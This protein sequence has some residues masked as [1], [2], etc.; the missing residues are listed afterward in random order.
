MSS[1]YLGN[2]QPV[3]GTRDPAHTTELAT[4][5]PIA[6]AKAI[7]NGESWPLDMLPEKLPRVSCRVGP[8]RGGNV[9]EGEEEES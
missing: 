8:R 5:P 9:R 4:T 2:G 3:L 7:P 6:P 1:G